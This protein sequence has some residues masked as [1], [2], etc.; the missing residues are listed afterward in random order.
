VTEEGVPEAVR[1]ERIGALTPEA[2]VRSASALRG[3]SASRSRSQGGRSRVASDPRG[4]A[5]STARKDKRDA[6]GRRR[7]RSASRSDSDS[8]GGRAAHRDKRGR[9]ASAARGGSSAGGGGG[10]GDDSRT[11]EKLKRELVA[12][13]KAAAAA[14][15]GTGTQKP[16][17][18]SEL[19]PNFRES[20]TPTL[21]IPAANGQPM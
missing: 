13:E 18:S 19:P 12:A 10:G 15:K 1:A 11:V 5:A 17:P 6:A 4:V 7:S 14:G 2:Q 16:L 3:R 9:S 20:A 8:D 21:L